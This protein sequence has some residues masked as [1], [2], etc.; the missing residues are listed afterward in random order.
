L[1]RAAQVPAYGW[2][3]WEPAELDVEAVV[4]EGLR[5]SNGLVSVEVDPADGTFSVNGLAGF[6]RLVDDGDFGDTYNWSPPEHQSV[7]DAPEE[8]DVDLIEP[9]PLRGRLRVRRTY[10]WPHRVDPTARARV[11]ER[12]VEVSSTIELHAG[13]ELVRMTTELDNTC[14]DH[15]LR[16]WLPL[17]E[18]ASFS[19]AESAFALVD[20]GLDHEGGPA[21]KPLP[22]YPSRRFV[23]AG[24]LTV[25][26]EGLLEFELCRGRGPV[27]AGGRATHLALTLLRATGML[28]RAEVAMRPVPAGPSLATRGS[29]VQG[30]HVLRWGVQVARD[31]A[32]APDP[33]ALVD[34]A[35]LP[36]EVVH[37]AGLG[38][39]P[40]RGSML[41]V[42]GGEVSALCRRPGGLQVRVFNPTD[43]EVTVRIE[44]RR[45][46]L[47]DL[48][49]RPLGPFEGAFDLGPWA[50]AT[51]WLTDA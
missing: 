2:A 15:R 10:R 14:E 48:R 17:P 33:W 30:P 16:T 25:V 26:H 47:V 7:V 41:S 20:R 40:E 3:R 35:F 13:E 32:P 24:G 37:A 18:P 9:G 27:G 21:E 34:D 44:G 51:A 23:Q 38:Q 19:R 45:G 29:Q 22:T 1:V 31:G 50:F 4:A 5:L 8:V 6:D 12:R 46:W 42:R 36:L 28:S 39:A 49:D 11:G 43:Q